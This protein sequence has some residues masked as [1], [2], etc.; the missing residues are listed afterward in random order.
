MNTALSDEA[1]E[2]VDHVRTWPAR[3]RLELAQQIISTV[4]NS[5]KPKKSLKSLLG[6]IA[7]NGAPPDDAACRTILEDEL[8][9]KH[10]L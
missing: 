1:R 9:S 8:L 2:I 4:N 6:R 5:G 3:S 10:K 7:L